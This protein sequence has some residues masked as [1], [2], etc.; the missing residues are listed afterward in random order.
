MEILIGSF[1]C[2]AFDPAKY[3]EQPFSVRKLSRLI[4][5]RGYWLIEILTLMVF[6]IFHLT[7]VCMWCRKD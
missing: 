7:W 2:D 4:H 3:K 5:W 6:S 1:G